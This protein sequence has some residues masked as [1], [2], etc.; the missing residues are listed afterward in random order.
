MLVAMINA[1]ILAYNLNT[2][3]DNIKHFN[4]MNILWEH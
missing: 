2:I 4:E 3:F 1:Y